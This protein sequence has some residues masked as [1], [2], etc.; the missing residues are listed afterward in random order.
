MTETSHQDEFSITEKRDE[1]QI[2]AEMDGIVSQEYFYMSRNKPVLSYL[3]VKEIARQYGNID[4][5]LIEMRE[6]DTAWF[7]V[8][9]ATDTERGNSRLG[10]STQLKMTAVRGQ[11]QVDEFCFQKAFSKA[12]RNAIKTLIPEAAFST[13]LETWQKQGG[14]SAPRKPRTSNRGN[15]DLIQFMSPA[16]LK[17]PDVALI[18]ELNRSKGNWEI[19][20][21]L[22]KEWMAVAGFR[23][24]DVGNDVVSENF[25]IKVDSVKI[26]LTP[27]G[28][29][30][31]SELPAINGIMQGG[32]FIP[33]KNG[34]Y[35][36]P[37][38]SVIG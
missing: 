19:A 6:T 30:S 29:I 5:E 16:D 2:L 3:G 33:L 36:I 21:Q 25:E 32:G 7:I 17:L 15:D 38:K 24:K 35:R 14:K 28:K 1:S 12:Q 34:K 22:T 10:A 26:E 9:K 37:K 13:A 8:I 18:D 27:K 31:A 23:F 11:P 20:E 4:T